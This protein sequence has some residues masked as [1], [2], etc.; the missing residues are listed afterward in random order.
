MSNG[1]CDHNSYHLSVYC[2]PRVA[3][4]F[5]HITW[6][7]PGLSSLGYFTPVSMNQVIHI[8]PITTAFGP[9]GWKLTPLSFFMSPQ[10]LWVSHM[11]SGQIYLAFLI[12]EL[13]FL[14]KALLLSSMK[15]FFFF[16]GLHENIFCFWSCTAVI[17]WWWAGVLKATDLGHGEMWRG[18]LEIKNTLATILFVLIWT[19]VVLRALVKLCVYTTLQNFKKKPC[20]H[21]LL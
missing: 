1:G 2:V 8:L 17:L 19:L 12:K 21:I 14:L 7:I 20:E 16:F 6:N 15:T 3:K 10:N 11:C 13:A 9:Y 4:S 18:G 5:T